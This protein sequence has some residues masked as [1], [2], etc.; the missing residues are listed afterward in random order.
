MKALE[1]KGKRFMKCPHC[2]RKIILKLAV[3]KGEVS[4]EWEI[5]ANR[6]KITELF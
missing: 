6:I 5:H 4:E 2:K 1:L 3:E